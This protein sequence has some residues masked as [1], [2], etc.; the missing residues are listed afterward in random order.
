MLTFELKKIW[1][2]RKIVLLIT[3]L[4]TV[5]IVVYISN[6]ESQENW[7]E[8]AFAQTDEYRS[9][10]QVEEKRLMEEL[11]SG[12][13][14]G[15]EMR[16]EALSEVS[17]TLYEWRNEIYH[18]N[19]SDYPEFEQAFI[20]GVRNY[21]EHG[22]TFDSL[23]GLKLEIAEAKT[24]WMVEHGIAYENEQYPLSPHLFLKDTSVFLFSLPG[25]ALLILLFG[26]IEVMERESHTWRLLRSTPLHSRLV[27]LSKFVSLLIVVVFYVF[28][29]IGTTL[30]LPILLGGGKV[31]WLYPIVVGDDQGFSIIS[32]SAW[33]GRGVLIF[34]CSIIF[35]FTLSI[36]VGIRT[37][38]SFPA[39]SITFFIGL[40][41]YVTADLIPF[42][43]H[44]FT[45]LR[46]TEIV[47]S[48]PNGSDW[49]IV[50]VSLTCSAILLV[51]ALFTPVS[52]TENRIASLR[53]FSGEKLTA[54]KRN[55]V[56]L[57]VFEW[58]KVKRL[59]LF[60]QGLIL[61]LLAISFGY[62]LLHESAEKHRET[63][64]DRVREQAEINLSLKKELLKWAEEAEQMSVETDAGKSGENNRTPADD[65]RETSRMYE[66][67]HSIELDKI[68]AFEERD[69]RR[70][71]ANQFFTIF[72][73]YRMTIGNFYNV[74]SGSAPVGIGTFN[75]DVSLAEKEW[76]MEHDVAPVFPGELAVS[77]RD[78]WGDHEKE[79][80][81]WK[82]ENRKVDAGGLFSIYH[83]LS[84][85]MYLLPI[86][87]FVFLLGGGFAAERG[88]K[89]PID[90]L[91]TQPVHPS[92]VFMGKAMNAVIAAAA[93]MTGLYGLILLLGT[94][95]Y[96]FGDWS[97]PILYYVP[98][99]IASGPD[100]GGMRSSG[101]GY[102]FI[103]LGDYVWQGIVLS[104]LSLAFLLILSIALSIFF[105]H[106]ATVL[107]LTF[108]LAGGG[109]YMA[110]TTLQEMAAYLPFT[111][112]EAGRILNGELATELN[113]PSIGFWTGAVVMALSIVILVVAGYCFLRSG[114][115]IKRG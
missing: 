86:L 2:S 54:G 76:M 30:L 26:N 70:F 14:P 97:Y 66:V 56:K 113:E 69:W 57:A 38:Y 71:Y 98:E 92:S 48:M 100:Y 103:P 88:K 51:L 49:K 85:A 73:S 20:K 47:Y 3:L 52:S 87:L 33:L 7:K 31:E 29:A 25:L 12:T 9:S 114:Y 39:L 79:R 27:L 80:R 19:W 44:A 41:G 115:K 84:S 65:M 111:Y 4:L 68:E 22:G 62:Y 10:I 91:L 60:R 11:E 110:R 5:I 53:R 112:L 107:A 77:V 28:I 34:A 61:L 64:F 58:R 21:Q 32:F 18:E 16:Q 55:A 72:S 42:P 75:E 43:Y 50:A 81:Q 96:R 90:F 6:R 83:L 101:Y 40:L 15:L 94:I 36:L 105:R 35:L 108:L 45:S 23:E 106:T 24:K 1:R 37:V 13:L 8:E 46:W 74:G 99:K 104:L 89:R 78:N 102:G 109:F 95:F 59:G 67:R 63:Y 93:S 17:R 82:A